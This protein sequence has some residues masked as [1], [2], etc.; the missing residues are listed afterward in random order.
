MCCEF[1][2]APKMK[3][4]LPMF[5]ALN[6]R[7]RLGSC[8]SAE[9]TARENVPININQN[10]RNIVNSPNLDQEE[11]ARTKKMARAVIVRR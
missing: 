2:N 5:G 4:R 8:P 10:P 7:M 6:P 11:I 3:V 1:N 9:P